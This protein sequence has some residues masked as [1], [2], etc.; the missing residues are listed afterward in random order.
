MGSGGDRGGGGGYEARHY[1]GVVYCA[2]V[3]GIRDNNA[4][5]FSRQ[6]YGVNE[7]LTAVARELRKQTGFEP[8]YPETSREPQ[9]DG[10][11]EAVESTVDVPASWKRA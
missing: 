1:A 5:L 2:T 4:P 7:P 6:I 11:A 9:R 3:V 8:E 10:L